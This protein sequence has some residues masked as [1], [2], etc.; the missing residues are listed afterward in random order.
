[1][2]ACPC[3]IILVA[4]DAKFSDPVIYM[5]VGAGIEYTAHYWELGARRAK[6]MLL[7]GRPFTAGEAREAGMVNHV[8]PTEQLETQALELAQEISGRDP[9]ALLMAKRV[10]NQSVDVSGFTA[11]I[12]SGFDMHQ[13]GHGNAIS[14]IGRPALG[15][16]NEVKKI[17]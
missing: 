2:L 1:M 3:D 17:G 8:V 5:G 11:S 4:V 6:E 15:W 13:N 14:H 7:T 16:L 12:Q 10:I 9:F